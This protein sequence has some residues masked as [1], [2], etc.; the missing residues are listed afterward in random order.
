MI[1]FTVCSERES[2]P[3]SCPALWDTASEYSADRSDFFVVSLIHAVR[4]AILSIALQPHIHVQLGTVFDFNE[5]EIVPQMHNPWMKVSWY[6][7][8]W[9]RQAE[10]PSIGCLQLSSR[11]SV[12]I[13]NDRWLG[14]QL[15]VLGVSSPVWMKVQIRL[16]VAVHHN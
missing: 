9:S 15:E 6:M 10:S 3:I 2:H 7:P 14:L 4:I 11:W 16:P 5:H 13:D 8:S 1:S 12:N